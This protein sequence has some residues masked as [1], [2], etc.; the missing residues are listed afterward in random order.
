MKCDK[1]KAIPC[2]ELNTLG[3]V[4]HEVLGELRG[5]KWV[6]GIASIASIIFQL[7]R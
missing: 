5:I 6:L 7:S 1:G 4:V 3:G 2:P